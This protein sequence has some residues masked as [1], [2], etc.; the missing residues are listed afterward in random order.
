MSFQN[1]RKLG[2]SVIESDTIVPRNDLGYLILDKNNNPQSISIPV[3]SELYDYKRFNIVVDTAFTELFPPVTVVPVDVNALL[4]Q[5]TALNAALSASLLVQVEPTPVEFDLWRTRK[6]FKRIVDNNIAPYGVGFDDWDTTEWGNYASSV[7]RI[8][9]PVL[10]TDLQQLLI[11]YTAEVSA[12]SS[13]VSS[14]NVFSP[15][16]FTYSNDSV[17]GSPVEVLD[18][19]DITALNQFIIEENIAGGISL[20]PINNPDII[21]RLQDLGTIA[22]VQDSEVNRLVWGDIPW[23]YYTKVNQNTNQP[24]ISTILDFRSQCKKLIYWKQRQLQDP[25]NQTLFSAVPFLRLLTNNAEQIDIQAQYN[26]IGQLE[27]VSFN[28]QPPVGATGY[29]NDII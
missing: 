29:F 9:G 12:I 10:T 17:Q 16:V 11:D 21:L 4:S 24:F 22:G 8:F 6:T 3:V 5:I 7:T 26:I 15:S 19:N 14:T 13:S 2:F 20:T 27:Q 28:G 1:Y 25:T 23:V 18:Y